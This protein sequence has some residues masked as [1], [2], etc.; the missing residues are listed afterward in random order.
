MVPGK[1]VTKKTT[2]KTTK[3][4]ITKKK[5]TKKTAKKASS[6]KKTTRKALPKDYDLVIVE[7]PS[8]AKTI[9]KYLGP[10]YMVVASNGHVKDL[11]K[12]KL[13]VDLDHG[14]KIDLVPI[15]G[16]KNVI[17]KI[18]TLAKNAKNIYLCPDPD[19][20]GEAIAYHLAEEIGK[21]A[22]IHRVLFNAIT[23]SS[24]RK[25]MDEPLDLNPHK[26]DSQ[27]TRR[28]LD[29]LVGYKISPILWDKVQRGLSAGRVQSV[30]LRIIVE[31]EQ[32]IKDFEP[33][34]WF[35]IEAILHKSGV[36]FKSLFWGD[37]KE[38]RMELEDEKLVQEILAHI[39]GK[40]FN[41]VDVTKKERKQNPTPPFTT[42]KLQQEAVNKLGFTTKKT[43]MVAQKL[44]EGIDTANF[45]TLGLITYMRTDSIRTEPEA[46]HKLREYIGSSY[47]KDYLPADPNYYKKKGG[48]KVQD[49]H[50]AIRPVD[51][52]I[53]PFSIK[54]DLGPDEYKLYS[55]IWNKFVASQMNPAI[56]DHTAVFFQVG[57][58][59]FKSNGGV[60]KFPGFRKVYL[61]SMVQN[62]GGK[63]DNERKDNFDELPALTDKDVLKPK[64]GPDS[65]EHWTSPPPRY[66]EAT[67]VKELE[68]KGIGR[69]S[70][71][72]SIISNIQDRS[73]VEKIESRF[74]PT[75]L[76]VIVCNML[77]ESFPSEMDVKFTANME[78]LLDN[79]E[80]GEIKWNK[81]LKDFWKS[82]EKTLEKAKEEMKNLKKQEIPSGLKCQKCGEGELLVKWGRNGSFLACSRYP[83]CKGTEEFRKRADGTYEIIPKDYANQPCPTCGKRMVVKK[84]RY[85][86][87]LACEEYPGCK[88]AL[89]YTIDVNCPE[90]KTGLF[91]EKQSRYGK[92][93]YGCT[94]YPDC[95]NASW[96]L[97]V[98]F[99]CPNCQ[100]PIMG[101]KETKRDGHHLYCSKCKTRVP[102][103][104]YKKETVGTE[105]SS[106]TD[107]VEEGGSL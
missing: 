35:S 88:T 74:H 51:V 73:Y 38:K 87:F 77:V 93:F 24:V 6:G 23:K 71:Y 102:Y 16:K 49:A 3:K 2:K 83:E 48:A 14:F 104:E 79:I 36:D 12:S 94:N 47:G 39:K 62:T 80:S 106:G 22:K 57:N 40:D 52:N 20:E 100:H 17:E 25:A 58:Y 9:K 19:R 31:K 7:S 44:Y 89:P 18:T 15:T 101:E 67:L 29:R 41:V 56:I 99:E 28:I 26:Y 50:E 63:G 55:L 30:A 105:V 69:P 66:S 27:R 43:M 61:D 84:G 4:K 59:F 85:G 86:R 53:T 42:S 5:T 10:G 11:P 90:C 45:G 60:L 81:V 91:A 21:K 54:N 76:G 34:Q 78:T 98:K 1:K 97:P 82:F 103:E 70:T 13:G 92:V 65:E 37:K 33:K 95:Q 72:S 96:S 32:A 107:G 8:K 68:E 64:K 75:E 46:L